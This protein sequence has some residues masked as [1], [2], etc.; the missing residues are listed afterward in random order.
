MIL[1]NNLFYSNSLFLAMPVSESKQVMTVVSH[2]CHKRDGHNCFKTRVCH[3]RPMIWCSSAWPQVIKNDTIVVENVIKKIIS[4]T[5]ISI[6]TTLP[7]MLTSRALTLHSLWYQPVFTPRSQ[8]V[9]VFF[10]MKHK[11]IFHLFNFLVLIY[12][13]T[14]FEGCKSA[15]L[16]LRFCRLVVGVLVKGLSGVSLEVGVPLVSFRLQAGAVHC[17][18]MCM[19]VVSHNCLYYTHCH[20]GWRTLVLKCNKNNYDWILLHFKARAPSQ[21]TIM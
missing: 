7:P 20:L 12:T 3:P 13:Y 15:L 10:G 16:H 11:L 17:M 6:H 8:S 21:M 2:R 18:C 4:H 14:R 9:I 1:L 19:Y 5:Y